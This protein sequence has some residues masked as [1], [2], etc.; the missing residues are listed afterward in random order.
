MW[1]TICVL[2]SL[3]VWIH[4]GMCKLKFNTFGINYYRLEGADWIRLIE[5]ETSGG[6]FWTE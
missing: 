5:I 4:N 1:Q 2:F 3:I 6:I